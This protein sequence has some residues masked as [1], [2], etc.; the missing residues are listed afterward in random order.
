MGP[1][2]SALGVSLDKLAQHRYF[3][4]DGLS[5]VVLVLVSL[6]LYAQTLWHPLIWDSATYIADNP[7]IQ[8]LINLPKFFTAPAFLDGLGGQTEELRYYRPLVN[9]VY[10]LGYAAVGSN[11]SA[12]HALQILL[13]AGVVVT[14]FYVLKKSGLSVAVAFA[15]MLLYA[16]NPGRAEGVNWVYGLSTQL[17]ALLALLSILAWLS[18]RPLW[19]LAAAAAALLCRESA[20]LLPFILGATHIWVKPAPRAYRW[21]GAHIGL[22]A[23]YLILRSAALGQFPP[24]SSATLP[25]LVNGIALVFAAALRVMM[26]PPGAVGIYPISLA[27]TSILE[28]VTQVALLLVTFSGGVILWRARKESRFWLIWVLLWLSVWFNV[29]RYGD[30]LLTEKAVYLAVLGLV[31]L[32]AILIQRRHGSVAIVL[33]LTLV[34]SGYTLWRSSY[35]HDPVSY[36]SA[37]IESAPQLATVHYQLGMAQVGKGDYVAAEQAFLDTVQL[38][39]GHSQALN[40]L[41]NIRFQRG[42]LQAAVRY[43][44]QASNADQGN[45]MPLYNLGM[46]MERMG[47]LREAAHYYRKY[48]ELTGDTNRAL[49]ERVL[50]LEGMS[51]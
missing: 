12:W 42:D 5:L 45:S 26:W 22:V 2:F 4:G 36:F 29:G 43:W 11:A 41:G 38:E 47:R 31:V 10:A 50:R 14:A 13:N 35:W 15:A 16:V 9:V 27:Q 32:F 51:R 19:S 21:L 33:A 40:N 30:Y 18:E 44:R 20:V 46:A 23:A 39:P 34:H 7:A 6:A 8:S 49:A 1:W 48:L 24:V 3:R 28:S 37:A 17:F 25:E